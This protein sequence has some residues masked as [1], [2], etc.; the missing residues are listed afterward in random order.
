MAGNDSWQRDQQE[1]ERGMMGIATG[2][3]ANQ[4]ALNYRDQQQKNTQAIYDNLYKGFDKGPATRSPTMA[5]LQHVRPVGPKP[6]PISTTPLIVFLV[7]ISG[8]IAFLIT[9]SLMRTGLVM[10]AS[11][12]GLFGLRAVC[13]IGWVRDLTSELLLLLFKGALWAVIGVLAALFVGFVAVVFYALWW[14]AGP[15][16]TG[17]VA[18]A[19]LGYIIFLRVAAMLG[20]RYRRFAATPDGKR[21]V[22]NFGIV[23]L[24]LKIGVL[25]A[26]LYWLAGA[27]ELV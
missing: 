23:T 26:G 21:F 6:V 5:P 25:G 17:W 24:A 9:G 18:A 7:L 3:A 12:A 22:R 8:G 20:T 14:T 15:E 16:V 2:S 27:L 1:R 13:R 4:Q 11:S 10:G 19:V